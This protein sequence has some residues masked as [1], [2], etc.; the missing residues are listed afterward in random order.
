MARKKQRESIYTKIRKGKT[1]YQVL[2][3]LYAKVDADLKKEKKD[4]LKKMNSAS[5]ETPWGAGRPK[6]PYIP[7]SLIKGLEYV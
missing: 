6:E 7:K 1:E 3:S 5:M 4:L 2:T